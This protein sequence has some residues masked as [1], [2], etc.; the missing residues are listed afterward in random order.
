MVAMISAISLAFR[1][2]REGTKSQDVHKQVQVKKEE[3]LRVVSMPAEKNG[4]GED[5]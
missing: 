2:K 5:A 3:R 4:Q 1:G